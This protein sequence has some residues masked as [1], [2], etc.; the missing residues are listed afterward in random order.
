MS[1]LV[2]SCDKQYFFFIKMIK[3]YQGLWIHQLD[4]RNSELCQHQK[5]FVETSKNSRIHRRTHPEITEGYDECCMMN[6]AY[7]STPKWKR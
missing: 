5:Y 1:V 4:D 2:N 3:S 6:V 7:V